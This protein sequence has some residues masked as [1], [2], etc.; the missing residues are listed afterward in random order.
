MRGLR[1]ILGLVVVGLAIVLG[2]AAT[3][4]GKH[5]Q[6]AGVGQDQTQTVDMEKERIIGMVNEQNANVAGE[7]AH[8]RGDENN[9]Q[10]GEP[11]AEKPKAAVYIVGDPEGREVL[12]MLV[13]NFLIR[14][15]KYQMIAV[16]AIDVIAQEHIRQMSGSVSDED[17]AALGQDAGAAYVCVVEK[18]TYGGEIYIGMRMVVVETKVAEFSNVMKVIKGEEIFDVVQEQINLMLGISGG[19][20]RAPAAQFSRASFIDSRDGKAYRTVK[21]GS[22]TWM[23]ENLNFEIDSSWCYD[24]DGSNCEKYGRLYDWEAAMKACPR[25]WR[26]PDRTEWYD[27]ER[28]SGSQKAAE[29]LKTNIGWDGADQFGWSALPGGYRY[30]M[31]EH[32][33]FHYG[34]TVGKW[35]TATEAYEGAHSRFMYSMR[36]DLGSGVRSADY[37]LSVRCVR[38]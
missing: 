28:H 30:C 19:G 18:S 16:D 7:Q 21:I 37:G 2:I 33:D 12:R 27:L 36:D 26:L 24:N 11:A 10:T 29:R 5:G 3:G 25:G 13:N 22:L 15:G 4:C 38:D 6:K 20:E 31:G 23:A 35:W 34:T 1:S 32:G 9:P 17:I 8:T 14:T